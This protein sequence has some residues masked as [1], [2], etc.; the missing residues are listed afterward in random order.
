MEKQQDKKAGHY[1]LGMKQRLGLA[2]AL[3]GRPPVLILDEPTNGLD[4]PGKDAFR[5][6]IAGGM[7]DDRTFVISTHQVRD[8]DQMLDHIIIMDDARILLNAGIS[9]IGRRLKFTLTDSPAVISSALYASPS[10]GER[11]WYFLTRMD[12]RQRLT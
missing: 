4:I 8:M 5:R 10:I 6:F 2:G 3:L 11:L 1:S 12:V 9:E 7:R